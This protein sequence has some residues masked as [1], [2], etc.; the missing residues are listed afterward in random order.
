M[1]IRDRA[2][3]VII[4]ATFALISLLALPAQASN[5]VLE[6]NQTFLEAV[7]RDRSSD[8]KTARGA[9]ILH[10]T[11]FDAVNGIDV[12]ESR[13]RKGFQA[14]FV[15]P[16]LAPRNASKT[17]S[18]LAAGYWVLSGLYPAQ[19]AT[20]ETQFNQELQTLKGSP[21]EIQQGLDWGKQ[22]ADDILALRAQDGSNGND[23][24]TPTTAIGTFST[25]WNQQYRNVTP[26]VMSS[27][28]QFRTA[29]P[30][31]LLSE[32]YAIDFNEVKD[33]GSVN[34]ATRTVD[35]T[36]IAFFWEGA[37]GT[38][39]PPGQWLLITKTYAE[40][41][42][43]NLSD[44]ARLFALMGLGL[45]DAGILTTDT[46]AAYS[47]WR[48]QAAIRLADQDNNPLTS[49]DSAWTP[50]N[51][52]QGGN[53]EHISGH[54][55][56]AGVG[57]TILARFHGKD[58]YQFSLTLDTRSG[59]PVTRSYS[60]FQQAARESGKSRIYLGIHFERAN[61]D[62][63]KGGRRLGKFLLKTQLLPISYR[64]RK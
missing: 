59:T 22:V 31:P 19:Q 21:A 57:S 53:P 17:A 2:R 48:P 41:E 61:Q 35:Q 54:S 30:N 26:F 43:L 1:L 13:F 27:P 56:F 11:I 44:S 60:S 55:T 52:A 46:K 39:T 32:A 5:I 18:A 33:I 64:S 45:G 20:F 34:S 28:S 40:Q 42:N 50:L 25:T 29:P 15:S 47:S 9:A 36:E 7:K 38:V 63:L 24:Y 12:R 37:A 10:V 14:Y 8:V 4:S 6:W 3:P 58:N 49:P 16:N 23:P 51:G 62:G